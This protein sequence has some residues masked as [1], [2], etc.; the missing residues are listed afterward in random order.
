M[1][2][3]AMH[4]AKAKLSEYIAASQKDRVLIT[5]HGRPAAIVIG[6]EGEE[7]EDLLTRAN[8]KFWEMIEE[9]RK[10]STVPLDDAKKYFDEADAFEAKH[11]RPMTAAAANRLVGG[12][13]KPTRAK[14]APSRRRK[15][16]GS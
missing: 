6:V 10:Q 11:G 14:R 16:A 15:Q 12:A 1:K 4:E 9:V 2:L 8:P 3:V 5:N 7:L 13:K